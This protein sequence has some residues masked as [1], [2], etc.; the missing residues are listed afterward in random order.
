MS[1]HPVLGRPA[2]KIQ[3]V[4]VHLIA[5]QESFSALK[6]A[7]C[8]VA[9]EASSKLLYILAPPRK[10][11]IQGRQTIGVSKS[12]VCHMLAQG[13]LVQEN[14]RDKQSSRAAGLFVPPSQS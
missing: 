8:R 7:V 1:T 14:R 12:I 10:Q 13:K 2:A 9:A 11:L 5:V 6:F 3:W 4:W